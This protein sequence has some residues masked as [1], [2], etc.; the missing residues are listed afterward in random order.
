MV[1]PVAEVLEE[2][3]DAGSSSEAAKANPAVSPFSAMAWITG[4]AGVSI[5]SV[6]GA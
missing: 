4:W 5:P 3:S 2:A 1:L 6:S